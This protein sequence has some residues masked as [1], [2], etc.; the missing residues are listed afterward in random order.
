MLFLTRVPY[1]PTPKKMIEK[2]IKELNIKPGQ[3]V[4]DLG[5]G[6]GRFLFAAEAKGA[7]AVGFEISPIVYLKA[8][9][10]KLLKRSKVKINYKNFYSVD[11][12]DAD[13]VFCF[14]VDT[15]IPKVAKKLKKEL[16]PG[17]KVVSYGFAFPNWEPTKVI[18]PALEDRTSSKVFIYEIKHKTT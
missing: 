7:K 8:R 18:I 10:T 16:K 15:V 3:L 2:I 12:S 6:D 11:L 1:A 13:V 14:L 17:T 9:L 4:Y 5:C